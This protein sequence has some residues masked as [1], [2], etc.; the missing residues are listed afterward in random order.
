[1]WILSQFVYYALRGYLLLQCRRTYANILFAQEIRQKNTQRSK[2]SK[3]K[4]KFTSY[5]KHNTSKF[6]RTRGVKQTV[7]AK[8]Q[9]KTSTGARKR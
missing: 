6:A 9:N 3:N 2:V 4:T 8:R 7:R 1:M 5:T